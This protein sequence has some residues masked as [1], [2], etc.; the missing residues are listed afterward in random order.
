MKKDLIKGTDMPMDVTIDGVRYTAVR[1]TPKQQGQVVWVAYMIN[2]VKPPYMK[3]VVKK[4]STIKKQPPTIKNAEPKKK[5]RRRVPNDA[6]YGNVKYNNE[7]VLY[8][9]YLLHTPHGTV[10]KREKVQV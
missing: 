4:E 7:R 3:D 10:V 2:P 9:T 8:L 5:A 1:F 6:W